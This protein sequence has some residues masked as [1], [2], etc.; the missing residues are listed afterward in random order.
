M[1]IGIDLGTT[2]SVAAYIN[3]A[4][5]PEIIENNQGED[6]TPSVVMVD[7]DEIKVG[8][9]AKKKAVLYPEK[10]R[11]RIKVDMG[12]K[13]PILVSGDEEYSPEALSHFILK[14]IIKDTENKMNQL[15]NGIVV[16]VPAYFSNTER[17]ATADAVKLLKNVKLISLIDE[18][19]AA[20]IYYAHKTKLTK[21]TILVYD[22]GG[23]TFDTTLLS[24]NGNEV[25]ILQKGGEH[26]AGGIYFDQYIADY[27]V[28]E[29]LG[30]YDIDLNEEKYND[31][32]QDILLQAEEC[33]KE[34]SRSKSS[35]ILVRVDDIREEIV[36]TREIFNKMISK[37]YNRTENVVCEV[38][39]LQGMKFYEV[40]KVLLVGGSSRIPY[41]QERLKALF[42][43]DIQYEVDPDKAVALGAALYGKM[44]EEK[45]NSEM[46]FNDVTTHA[47][48][49]VLF[50]P[51]NNQPYNSV[52][53][54]AN[55]PLPARAQK[56]F[57]T[58]QPNQQSIY[59][60]VTEG[61]FEELKYVRIIRE[62]YIEIEQSLDKGTYVDI[63]IELDT[64]QMLHVYMN[65]PSTG[66]EKEYEINGA[67]NL[68]KKE[69]M[70]ISGLVDTKN[71]E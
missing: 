49:M 17:T 28:D 11:S 29:I 27:V 21:G 46:V 43:K 56:R 15:V 4:G 54:P 3:D 9:D 39:Q 68:S 36:I 70:A 7:G 40:D 65:I 33:K 48:G 16:T 24:I 60:A 23:G 61:E 42:E 1:N 63:S 57:A 37:M 47:V 18:P 32:Y 44:C 64:Q 38:L 62:E 67:F 66:F 41:I 20:A 31:I 53:I 14:K 35:S 55:T 13:K 58:N 71:V 8:K 50:K 22:L 2:Y 52:L 59:M 5:E 34:L 30:N 19:T 12:K 6:I 69:L 51:N 10:V 25:N 45:G 26:E